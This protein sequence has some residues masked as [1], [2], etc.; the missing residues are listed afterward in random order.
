MS[1]NS[2]RRNFLQ[3]GTVATAGILAGEA[4][5]IAQDPP[6][7]HDHQHDHAGATPAYPRERPGASGPVGSVNDRG[8]LVPGLRAAGLPPVPV[9]VPDLP[10]RLAW[11]MVDGAKEFHLYCRHTRREFLPD[12]YMDVWGFN[13]S[14]PGPTIEVNQGD[15]VRIWVHNELPESTGIHWHGLEV[16]VALDGVPGLTQPP[17][18]PGGA[19]AYEFTLHQNGT[20]FYHSHDG[21]QDGMGMVG[22]FIIHPT[23]AYEP[24]VDRDFG[25]IIQEWAVLPGS[26]IPN[27][28]SMEFNLFTINGRAAPYVTPLVCKLGERVR[29]RMV[30]FSAIDHH[31]MHL[32]GLTIIVTGTEGGRIQP[33][34][35]VPGNTVLIGVAQAREI[36]FIANNPGDWM[37]HCHMFHHVMNFMSSMVGPMG[38]HTI[39]GMRAGQ[40]A[41]GGMG[42]ATGGPAL[43]DAYGA[44]LGRSMGE[45]TGMERAVGTGPRSPGS[46]MNMNMALP[47]MTMP[48]GVRGGHAGH[49]GGAGQLVPGY[50]QG[51]MDMAMDLPEAMLKKITGKRETR[52]MR[53]DWHT[54]LQGL[55]SVVRVLPPDLYDAVMSGEHEVPAGASIPGNK[56]ADGMHEHHQH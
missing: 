32:H 13:D 25:L 55:M 35:W 12:L 50:P 27:T 33:S 10:E 37:L 8:M 18:P 30:N 14:M 9:T 46:M 15:R 53:Q 19:Q 23:V 24:R 34:A 56:P 51:M 16:P 28:M 26:T 6:A 45:Q 54:G 7:K 29:I 42:I 43:S 20:Y 2:T 47:G 49:G 40:S 17:I 41:T 31:P 22:L 4:S 38:G 1:T 21:M 3:S 5:A 48:A 39:E 52:G 36:E 44:S 11:K